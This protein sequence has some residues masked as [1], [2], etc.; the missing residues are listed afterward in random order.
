MDIHKFQHDVVGWLLDCFGEDILNN[1]EERNYRFFEEAAELVQSCGMT[2]EDCYKLID[3]V[4]GRPSGE[5]A[6]EI[7]GVMVTLFGLASAQNI[8]VDAISQLEIQSCYDRME[9]IRAKWLSKTV[10]SG[11]PLPGMLDSK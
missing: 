5:P 8:S 10:K 6:Q 2:K 3:Y 1:K 11:D 4:Y 7:G 9:K